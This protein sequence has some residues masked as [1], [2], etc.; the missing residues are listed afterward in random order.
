[1]KRQIKTKLLSLLALIAVIAIGQSTGVSA[2]GGSG[3]GG[4]GGSTK[5]VESRVTGYCTFLDYDSGIV[6]IGASYYGTGSLVVTPDTD[7]SLDNVSCFLDDLVL[8]D[9]V[10]ARYLF[11]QDPAT[12]LYIRVATK[13]SATSGPTS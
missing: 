6:T 13:L 7:I 9:W 10:E 5:V 3:G 2:K 11:V 8:G 1:M 12:G 4:G